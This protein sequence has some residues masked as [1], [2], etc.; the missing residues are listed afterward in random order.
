MFSEMTEP[1]YIPGILL[2]P[3][4]IKWKSTAKRNSPRQKNEYNKRIKINTLEIPIFCVIGIQAHYLLKD[5]VLE[6]YNVYECI[7]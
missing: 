3:Y 4:Y 1:Y 6:A 7:L 5:S 2:E